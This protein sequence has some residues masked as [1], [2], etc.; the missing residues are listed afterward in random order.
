MSNLN[1]WN[2]QRETKA[3]TV[4]LKD[5]TLPTDEVGMIKIKS[6]LL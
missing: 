6:S 5:I 1:V 4:A 2:A 3:N